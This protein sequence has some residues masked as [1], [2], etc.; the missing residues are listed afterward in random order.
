MKMMQLFLC[1]FTFYSGY[2]Q[3]VVDVDKARVPVS[4]QVF[5]SAGGFPVSIAKYV[6]LVSGSPYFS[7]TWMKGSVLIND[8]TEYS[9]LRL[10]LDLLEGSLSYLNAANEEMISVQ[11][12]KAVSLVDTVSGGSYLF[13]HSSSVS[14][15]P[16]LEKTW[17]QLLTGETVILYK[18]YFKRMLESK[19]YASSITEQTIQTEERFFISINNTFTRVKKPNDIAEFVVNKKQALLDFIQ[20]NKLSGKKEADFISAVEY[21]NSLK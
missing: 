20:K 14:G 2:N 4:N 18:Q 19:A 13:V 6:Q 12:V 8:S 1:L 9:N 10:R 11:P 15:S 21:Y 5:Y 16:R 3:V 7:E 17:Y